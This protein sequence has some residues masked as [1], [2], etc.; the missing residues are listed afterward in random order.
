MSRPLRVVFLSAALL[1]LCTA[2]LQSDGELM[3]SLEVNLSDQQAATV[4]LRRGEEAAAA[5]SEFC[6]RAQQDEACVAQIAGAL[7]ERA[8]ERLRPSARR[9]FSAPVEIDGE[10]RAFEVLEG[11]HPMDAAILF[12]QAHASGNAGCAA[13][14]AASVPASASAGAT[15]PAAADKAADPNLA[16]AIARMDVNLDGQSAAVVLR[17]GEEAEA[18]AREFCARAPQN[19]GCVAQIAGA[20]REQAAQSLRPSARRVFRTSVEIDGAQRAFEVLEG[21]HPMDAAILFCQAHASG[22]AGCAAQLAGAVRAAQRAGASPASALEGATAPAKQAETEASRASAEEPQAVDTKA[23]R[24][25][26][27]ES[28]RAEAEAARAAARRAEEDARRLAKER[29][30]A[31]REAAL[32]AEAELEAAERRLQA[33]AKAAADAE[34]EERVASVRRYVEAAQLKVYRASYTPAQVTALD[35]KAM[36]AYARKHKKFEAEFARQT[37]AAVPTEFSQEEAGDILA[38]YAPTAESSGAFSFSW[39]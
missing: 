11:Q 27:E 8:A 16:R 6:A 39:W 1:A 2:Q 38:Q 30:R 35:A 23:A 25:A 37:K 22:N 24:A 20:L 9:V 32:R 14:L 12:C 4:V 29:E 31:E 3:V 21:Q 10:Q 34:R 28:K 26:A 17:H 13:Q 5:A 36:K 18:V 15:A 19:V 7:R 33:E